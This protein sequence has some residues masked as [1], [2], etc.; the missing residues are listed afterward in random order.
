MTD[1]DTYDTNMFDLENDLSKPFVII[2]T[3]GTGIDTLLRTARR[4]R[5]RIKNPTRW[6]V[7]DS[8]NEVVENARI[9]LRKIGIPD[10]D[11]LVH[12][13]DRE[14][15]RLALI[16]PKASKEYLEILEAGGIVKRV[17][18]ETFID[19]RKLQ[20]A[21]NRITN[22]R[23]ATQMPSFSRMFVTGAN[24]RLI[25]DFSRTF[26]GLTNTRNFD[27]E[28]R[29]ISV[30]LLA[31]SFGGTGAG[32]FLPILFLLRN[33]YGS[34]LE[35]KLVLFD[36]TFAQSMSITD[37]EKKQAQTNSAFTVRELDVTNK[38]LMSTVVNGTSQP[39][40]LFPSLI[41][42]V[43]L[44]PEDI[45]FDETYL[46][47][48]AKIGGECATTVSFDEAK[49]E[50]AAGVV[51]LCEIERKGGLQQDQDPFEAVSN[52]EYLDAITR[53][54]RNYRSVGHASIVFPRSKIVDYLTCVSMKNLYDPTVFDAQVDPKNVGQPLELPDIASFTSRTR[55]VVVEN[56]MRYREKR[57]LGK[58]TPQGMLKDIGVC[59]ADEQKNR[60]K[61][62]KTQLGVYLHSISAHIDEGYEASFAVGDGRVDLYK[63]ILKTKRDQ[64]E[65]HIKAI[66][67][68]WQEPMN[69]P[70]YVD[71]VNWSSIKN[72]RALLDDIEFKFPQTLLRNVVKSL[73]SILDKV[74]AALESKRKENVI[75]RCKLCK[76]SSL[77][78]QKAKALRDEIVMQ[79]ENVVDK[80][81]LDLTSPKV[82]FDELAQWVSVPRNQLIAILSGKRGLNG[83]ADDIDAMA[84][85]NEKAIE[86]AFHREY[87]KRCPENIIDYMISLKDIRRDAI[88]NRVF[89][90]ATPLFNLKI[91]DGM[92]SRRASTKI[93]V[94]V[95]VLSAEKRDEFEAI[96]QG[97]VQRV[98]ATDELMLNVVTGGVPERLEVL[99]I[100]VGIRPNYSADWASMKATNIEVLE[101]GDSPLALPNAIR[102]LNDYGDEATLF[103]NRNPSDPK[104]V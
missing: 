21:I 100:L 43:N 9:E 54:A 12:C 71:A 3:G 93:Y 33:L 91:H 41:T 63:S 82:T 98:G 31:S 27:T 25:D 4:Y 55:E 72:K 85:Q 61:G 19:D 57:L 84:R 73:I 39:E 86:T 75:L 36:G 46:I 35:I 37:A 64:L 81:W 83:L 48:G 70:R 10:S 23:G 77:L 89:F 74:V 56:T 26:K 67:Q 24:K 62:I 30:T 44:I 87:S 18:D 53:E 102:I 101:S 96:L 60:I 34:D 42:N 45:H 103:P 6:I 76:K 50:V 68:G 52:V 2:G 92:A 15:A 49:E 95:P 65:E 1:F 79:S 32:S 51:S 22:G 99:S 29:K 104:Q 14:K 90:K 11:T 7:I 28:M 38:R 69:E 20:E 88:L 40:L 94:S 66:P 5:E 59:V 17:G 97:N 16:N 58:C 78:D 8:N 47:E 80:I 13:L